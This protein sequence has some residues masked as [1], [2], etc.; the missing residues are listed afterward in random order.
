[1][2]EFG[3]SWAVEGPT[4]VAPSTGDR[5]PIERTPEKD[6]ER[7]AA[8]QDRITASHMWLDALYSSSSEEAQNVYES[9]AASMGAGVTDEMRA[10][11][12][13]QLADVV[14]KARAAAHAQGALDVVEELAAAFPDAKELALASGPEPVPSQVREFVDNAVGIALELVRDAIE[15]GDGEIRELLAAQGWR[16]VRVARTEAVVAY[17]QSRRAAHDD[18]V[19]NHNDG[20]LGFSILEDEDEL[21]EQGRAKDDERN[22]TVV[23]ALR[24]GAILDKRTCLRC[25]EIDGRFTILALPFN[26]PPLHNQCRC[27]AALWPIPWTWTE[28]Q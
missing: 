13:A 3:L 24:W 7:A 9:A 6:A 2:G 4:S 17:E 8:M 11:M 18:L 14:Q 16:G 5:S 15:S 22:V 12:T 25:R 23:L 28:E 1:M 27:V 19:R 21:P 20:A 26:G 10:T